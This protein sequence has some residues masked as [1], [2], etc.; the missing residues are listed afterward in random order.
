M[1]GM[2]LSIGAIWEDSMDLLSQLRFQVLSRNLV[3]QMDMDT[4]QAL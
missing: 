2:E 3:D 4:I 1:G